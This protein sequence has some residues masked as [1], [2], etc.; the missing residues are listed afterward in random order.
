MASHEFNFVIFSESLLRADP[1]SGLVE[2]EERLVL[3]SWLGC[4]GLGQERTGCV[5]VCACGWE[6]GR[7]PH[8]DSSVGPPTAASVPLRG[9]ECPVTP[10]YPSDFP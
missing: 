7:R 5:C 10:R 8:K 9:W 6:V 3:S 1:V 2:K 4:G